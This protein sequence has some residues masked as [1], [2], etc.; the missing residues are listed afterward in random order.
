MRDVRTLIA[1]GLLALVLS[2][3]AGYGGGSA[4]AAPSEP[5]GGG[6]A[7]AAPKATPVSSPRP[8]GNPDVD[9]YGY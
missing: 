5:A 1:A 8:S 7:T 9:N 6:A 3:C 2:S 4:P